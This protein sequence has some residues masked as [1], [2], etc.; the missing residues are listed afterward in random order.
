MKNILCYG[1]SNTWGAIPGDYHQRFEYEQRWTGILQALLGP[2][3]RVIEEGLSGRTTVLE[4]FMEEGRNGKTWLLPCLRTHRPLDLVV[5]MLGTNDLKSRFCFGAFDI[6]KAAALL[7]NIILQ[8]DS[9]RD[10]QAPQVLLVAPPPLGPLGSYAGEFIGGAAKSK[11][12]G[13][14][15]R[16]RAVET[17]CLFLDAGSVITSSPADGVHF[18]APEH[19]KLAGAIAD[20][21]KSSIK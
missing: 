16:Q 20:I 7:V 5:L 15:Y 19:Q 3:Y 4:D 1:D 12:M 11:E 2:D 18:D 13:E 14:H 17:G 21:I 9:G 8:S 10:G 6:A